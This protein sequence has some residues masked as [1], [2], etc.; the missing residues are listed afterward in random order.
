MKGIAVGALCISAAW[1]EINGHETQGLWLIAG[2]WI[3]FGDGSVVTM[4][5]SM[6]DGADKE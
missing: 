6:K 5:K 2:L 1:L 4:Y 3:F